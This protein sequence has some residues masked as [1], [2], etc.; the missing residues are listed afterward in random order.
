MVKV[1]GRLYN[2]AVLFGKPIIG[3]VGGI[4]SGKSFI[5]DL[6]GELGC[7]SIHSDK[8]VDAAYNQLEVRQALR[9]W[10]G[11]SVFQADGRIDRRAI[12]ARV[13]NDPNERGRLEGLL[14]PMVEQWRRE[15]MAQAADN[16]AVLAFVWDTPL[17]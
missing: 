9:N 4:G 16:P 13:F 8:L 14:H 1:W 5:A 11:E 3:L 15:I 12:A 7:M 17:L 2:P 10:W 6:F